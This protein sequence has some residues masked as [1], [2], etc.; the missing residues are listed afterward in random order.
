MKI[1][2]ADRPVFRSKTERDVAE[3]AIGLLEPEGFVL[4]LRASGKHPAIIAERAGLK[5]VLPFAGTPSVAGRQPNYMR[6]K[7]RQVLAGVWRPS[8]D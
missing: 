3:V 5:F 8:V 6:Q 2:R 4:T 7:C 1:D